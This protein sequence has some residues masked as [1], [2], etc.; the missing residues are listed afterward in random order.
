MILADTIGTP[1]SYNCMIV[2]GLR[3]MQSPVTVYNAVRY[4]LSHYH[5][6]F[7]DRLVT[8]HG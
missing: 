2:L 7:F 5:D 8:R 4:N 1:R 3:E 6:N